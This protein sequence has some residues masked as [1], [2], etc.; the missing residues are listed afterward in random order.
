MERTQRAHVDWMPNV[1]CNRHARS[2]E[3]LWCVV[4]QAK[5]AKK[6]TTYSVKVAMLQIY[7]EQVQDLLKK[8]GPNLK[9]V[10]DPQKYSPLLH[11]VLIPTS[12]TEPSAAPP[13][14]LLLLFL[15]LSLFS[16]ISLT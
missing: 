5:E 13:P 6:N 2:V 1:P 9:I 15:I 16:S 11:S 14:P 8:G 7:N 10:N 12:Y 3:G 4:L